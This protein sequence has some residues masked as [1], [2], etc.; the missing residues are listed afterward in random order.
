MNYTIQDLANL[1]NE[2]IRQLDSIAHNLAN[3]ATPGFK[4]QY[5]HIRAAEP[6][7]FADVLQNIDHS[8]GALEHTGNALDVAL[9]G[10][11]FFAVQT[12]DGVAYTRRGNFLLNAKQELVTDGGM[13]VLGEGGRITARGAD[14]RID[15]TGSVIV[16]GSAGD[17][18]KIVRFAKPSALKKR[19][20]GLFVDP[21][22]EM[23]AMIEVQRTFETYTKLIQNLSDLDRLSTN[24]VGKLV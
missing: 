9:Q 5:L 16:D 14:V 8:Q 15:G 19:G 10:E 23:V 24:R 1:S 4:A 7:R 3:A 11:G 21:G 2:K 18:L 6:S 20:D 13:A 22:E 12:G 17:K